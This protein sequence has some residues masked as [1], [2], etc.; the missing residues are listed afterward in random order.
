MNYLFDSS[1]IVYNGTPN[2]TTYKNDTDLYLLHK[3]WKMCLDDCSEFTQSNTQWQSICSPKQPPYHHVPTCILRMGATT[4][5]SKEEKPKLVECQP[6]K[7]F[8]FGGFS[9]CA[10]ATSI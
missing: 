10:V 9:I 3:R 1:Y 4:E 8:T 6:Q 2:M 5:T 7:A